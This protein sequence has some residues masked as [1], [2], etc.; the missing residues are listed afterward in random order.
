MIVWFTSVQMVAAGI[1]AL[2]CLGAAA[3]RKKPNDFTMGLTLLVVLGLLAQTVTAIIAPF[4][5]NAPQG[6]LLE[7][8]LYLLTA[9]A[10]PVGGGFWALIDRS[11]WAHLVLAVIGFSLVVMLYRMGDIWGIWGS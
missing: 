9:L 7:Y 10:L 6:D 3:L 11:V 5:G 1:M 2:C 8:W 4:V